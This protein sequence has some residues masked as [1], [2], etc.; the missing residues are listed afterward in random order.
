MNAI[1]VSNVWHGLAKLCTSEAEGGATAVW[2]IGGKSWREAMGALENRLAQDGGCA[3]NGQGTANVA[4]AL[5]SLDK[6]MASAEPRVQGEGQGEG[7]GDRDGG[8]RR[9]RAVVALMRRALVTVPSMSPAGLVMMLASVPDLVRGVPG[10]GRERVGG[11]KAEL[12]AEAVMQAVKERACV[13]MRDFDAHAVA[14]S[15][16]LLAKH[17]GGAGGEAGRTLRG[18]SGWVPVEGGALGQEECE[19][20]WEGGEGSGE[21]EKHGMT[22]RDG[23]LYAALVHQ[24]VRLLEPREEAP[25]VRQEKLPGRRG[26][27]RGHGRGTQEPTA[28]GR[29][30]LTQRTR[31]MGAQDVAMVL[32]ALVKL[33]LC[34]TP[35][36]ATPKPETRNPK[37]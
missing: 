28:S 14:Q 3:M 8:E 19:D 18:E 29:Q 16:S 33:D 9:A 6:Q 27:E 21:V 20:E 10:S 37:P 17:A 36:Q 13:T 25:L 2:D 31:P 32:H 35:N 30:R 12:L 15:L 11:E 1:D 5:S 7:V 34:F 24:A 23:E 26:S 22:A 4:W